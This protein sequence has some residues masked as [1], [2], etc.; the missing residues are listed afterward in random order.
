MMHLVL[1]GGNDTCRSLCDPSHT[2]TA[3]QAA[4]QLGHAGTHACLPH[5][6]LR[7]PVVGAMVFLSPFWMAAVCCSTRLGTVPGSI[8]E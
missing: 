3:S 5:K 2:L 7:V 1:R 8:N 6:V 4:L